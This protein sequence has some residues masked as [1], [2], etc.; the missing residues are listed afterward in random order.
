MNNIRSIYNCYGCGICSIIC[1]KKIIKIDYNYQGFLVPYIS[2]ID[3]CLNCGA[4]LSVC[5]YSSKGIVY[6]SN[7]IYPKFYA[8]WSKNKETRNKCSS[9]GVA[10]EL[11]HYLLEKK[12]Y[13]VVG[14]KY[15]ELKDRAENY[16]ASNVE[17]LDYSIGSKYIQS[18][19]PDGFSQ[20][21]KTDKYFVTG[22]PCQ[23]EAIR[24]YIQKKKIE[25]NFILM[26]FFCHGVPSILLWKKYIGKIKSAIDPITFVSWRN[27]ITDWHNSFVIKIKGEFKKEKKR[28]ISSK[29]DGDLFYRF[30]L[31]NMCLNKV[32]YSSCKYKH[33][34]SAADIRVGDLWGNKYSKNTKGVNGIIVLTDKGESII[35]SLDINI[36]KENME[37][38]TEGQLKKCLSEPYYYNFLNKLFRTSLSLKIIFRI[39]QILRLKSIIKYKLHVK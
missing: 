8:G 4:C 10:Y 21:N 39:T 17:E 37:V 31:G 15:N 28:Y 35:K 16:I 9:G 36:I 6:S 7:T 38:V 19:T 18:Y 25:D 33:L 24:R 20:I 26:D 11:A 14:V 23:I 27:K 32:C 22:T 12:H 3:K 34:N 13:K 2:E 1:P 5:V 29:S 30:F